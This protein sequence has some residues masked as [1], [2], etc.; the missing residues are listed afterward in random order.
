MTSERFFL[1]NGKFDTAFNEPLRSAPA[2]SSRSTARKVQRTRS[3]QSTSGM[4]HV[5]PVLILWARSE[6]GRL[7]SPREV[8][9]DVVAGG[10][11]DSFEDAGS[12]SERRVPTEQTTRQGSG[13]VVLGRGWVSAPLKRILLVR[14]SSWGA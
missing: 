8:Q 14:S 7:W 11:E 2:P 12:S 1:F 10:S 5:Q 9:V 4:D 6:Q 13:L 3:L